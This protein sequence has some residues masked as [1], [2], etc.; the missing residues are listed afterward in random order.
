MKR[1]TRKYSRNSKKNIK[2]IKKTRRFRKQRGG[3]CNTT[4]P[5]NCWE[6][7]FETNDGEFYKDIVCGPHSWSKK[8]RCRNYRGIQR[9]KVCS[10]CGEECV[11]S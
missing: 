10:A 3:A 2:N 4:C 6:E 7:E 1:N 9:C 11:Y 5:Q 8:A